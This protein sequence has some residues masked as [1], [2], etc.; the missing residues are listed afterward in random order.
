MTMILIVALMSPVAVIAL[1]NLT[2]YLAGERGTLLLPARAAYP[3]T[4]MDM[5]PA[6]KAP[7]VAPAEPEFV[8]E[9]RMAA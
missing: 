4:A 7:A 6:S 1:I 9:L 5:L 8:E 2:L 3:L